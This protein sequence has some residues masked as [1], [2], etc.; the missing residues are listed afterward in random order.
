MKLSPKAQRF[1]AA[2]VRD[3]PSAI[4]RD[5]LRTGLRSIRNEEMS[6]GF[7]PLALAALCRFEIWLKECLEASRND[8]EKEAEL[9]N[10]IRFVQTVEKLLARE[11][12]YPAAV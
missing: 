6:G 1:V 7:A 8:E 10:D 2:A 5:R 4:D 9:I 3:L 12:V 11:G